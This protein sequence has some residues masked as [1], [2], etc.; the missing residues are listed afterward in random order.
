MGSNPGLELKGFGK[1]LLVIGI[2]FSVILG[3]FAMSFVGKMGN[4]GIGFIVGLVII[5]IGI[6]LSWLSN[7]FIIAFGELVENSTIIRRYIEMNGIG[8]VNPVTPGNGNGNGNGNTYVIKSKT[9]RDAEISNK[10][11]I[12][13]NC[14]SKNPSSSYQCEGCG[15]GLSGVAVVTDPSSASKPVT[16]K[17][18]V[19]PNCGADVID[20][21]SKYCVICGKKIR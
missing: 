11:K 12:C 16:K 1:V 6:F 17:I 13:P 8:T 14:G 21:N 3:I 9:E 15:M 18:D 7:I 5:V 19:C 20:S 4:G 2:I 10:V